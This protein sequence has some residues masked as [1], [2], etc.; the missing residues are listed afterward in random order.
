MRFTYS[1]IYTYYVLFLEL[2]SDLLSMTMNV[3]TP[4]GDFL[5]VD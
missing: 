1:Y 4:V 3:S 2:N 5:V